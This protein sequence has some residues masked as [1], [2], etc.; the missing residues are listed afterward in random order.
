[1]ISKIVGF[2]VILALV[3]AIPI[4]YA[5]EFSIG[6]KAEQKS[7]KVVINSSD[8]IHVMHVI[9]FSDSPKQIEL[10]EGTITN[11]KV[12]DEEGKEKQFA[13]IGDNDSIMI[14]PSQGDII[15]EYDLQNVLFLKDNVWTWNFLYLETTSFIFPEDVDLIFVNG[16]PVYLDE[17]NGIA[18]HGCQMTLEYS[19][20]EP[21]IL[22]NVEFDNK[23]FP[24][25][26]RTFAKINQFEFEQLT[27]RISFKVDGEKQFVT[28]VIPSELSSKRYNVLLDD[29]KIPFHSYTDNQ[30]SIWLS[31][32]PDNSGIVSITDAESMNDELINKNS[33]SS[34]NQDIII[35]IIF[36][37]IV[38]IGLLV[39]IIMMRRK[40]SLINSSSLK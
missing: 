40:K 13:I 28:I 23:G 6:E 39:I 34:T 36:G 14:Y 26:I 7:V 3:I 25:E 32:R 37:V 15:V 22:E 10:I 20:N 16:R 35:Y 30:T 31:I 8:K 21:K 1:M 38:L 11:I 17:K 9:T 29:E 12:S 24:I 18:C 33:S 4:V 2:F 19:I 27:K 5:Q